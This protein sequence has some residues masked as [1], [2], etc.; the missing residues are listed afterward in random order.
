MTDK[1]LGWI[2]SLKST[3]P[4][5]V[6]PLSL[7]WYA[8]YPDRIAAMEAVKKAAKTSDATVEISREM[9]ETLRT[10]LGLTSRKVKR[11]G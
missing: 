6:V 10:S 2:V 7:V 3:T 11:F 8:A 9:S 5:V 1:A 4:G